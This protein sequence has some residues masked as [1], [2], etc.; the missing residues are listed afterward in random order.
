MNKRPDAMSLTQSKAFT[1]VH[2]DRDQIVVEAAF[3]NYPEAAMY[4]AGSIYMEPFIVVDETGLDFSS[5]PPAEARKF[6]IQSI[7]YQHRADE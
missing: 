2:Q 5:I 7:E 3:S 6:A 1:V 4:L